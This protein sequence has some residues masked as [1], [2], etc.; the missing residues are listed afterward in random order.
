MKIVCVYRDER[1][2]PNYV[3]KDRA[4]LDAVGEKLREKGCQVTF[5]REAEL[6]GIDADACLSMA[7]SARA[8]QIERE[9]GVW[10]VNAP[11]G[12]ALCC[13]RISLDQLM[14]AEKVAMPPLQGSNG[15][16]LKRGDS[17]TETRGDVVFCATEADEQKALAAFRERG[18]SEVVRSA[19]VEGDVVKFYGVGDGQLFRCYYPSDDGISKFGD[20]CRNGSSHHYAF[21]ERQLKE[22]VCRLARAVGVQV[23]GGDCVVRA[24]GSFAIIDFTDWPSFSRCR[25]EAATAIASLIIHLS[26]ISSKVN[27]KSVNSKYKNVNIQGDAS[28]IV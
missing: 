24:D 4:I 2:S 5:V 13:R 11:E 10:C 17:S 21:D 22:E 27:S 19:H 6:S 20:E 18:I 3:E 1:Y 14:R 12:V 25:E 15:C 7:R 16:W 9:S 28:G 23:Y 8:L 26:P